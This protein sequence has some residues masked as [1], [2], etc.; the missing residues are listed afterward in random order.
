MNV[1]RYL[2]NFT[3]RDWQVTERGTVRMAVI[4]LGTF[5]VNRAIP[6]MQAGKFCEPTVLVS[7]SPEKASVVAA[8]HG[9][10]TTLGYDAFVNGAAIDRYDAVYI[11]T[12]PSFHRTYTE[13]AAAHGKHVLCE[14]PLASTVSDAEA[15][16]AACD[17]NGVSLMTAYRLRTEPLVRRVR[18]M[19]QDGLIGLVVHVDAEFS[20]RLAANAPMDTWRL[21]PD[22]A[23]GGALMDVGIH[24]LN[25]AR[26]LLDEEPVTASGETVSLTPPFDRVEEHASFTLRFDSGSI[27]TGFTS[28]NAHPENRLHLHGTAGEILIR[29]PFGGR[30]TQELVIERHEARTEY[31]GDAVDEVIEEFDYFANCILTDAPCEAAGRDGL[32]DLRIVD[33]IYTAASSGQRQH[34]DL[35]PSHEVSARS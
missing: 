2:E 29:D 1:E 7:S 3:R 20:T 8:E 23:G 24:P 30:V 33:A 9:I 12:P 25:L 27:T 11:A 16:V 6:G 22:I 13:A 31:T 34:L 19:V 26:F 28:F 32:A 35:S 21:N 17:R 5:A 18:E 15:M 4:G 10:E 14:K